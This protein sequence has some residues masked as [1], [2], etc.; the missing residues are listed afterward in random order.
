MTAAE[1]IAPLIAELDSMSELDTVLS[2][3]FARRAALASV[4]TPATTTS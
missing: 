2:L 1:R 4:P 3:V